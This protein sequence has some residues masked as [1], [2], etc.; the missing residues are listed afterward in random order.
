MQT[1]EEVNESQI[2]VHEVEDSEEADEYEID[3]QESEN[4]RNI[5]CNFNV[6]K[7][8]HSKRWNGF[9]SCIIG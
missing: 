3:S 8:H 9:M 1:D 2:L 7:I 4:D 6:T 5:D